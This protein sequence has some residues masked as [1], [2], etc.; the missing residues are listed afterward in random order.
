[1]IVRLRE[2]EKEIIK[3]SDNGILKEEAH[4]GSGIVKDEDGEY[5]YNVGDVFMYLANICHEIHNTGNIESEY[6]FI[7]I[8]K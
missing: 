6:I 5:P 2:S 7:R 8:H 4:E 3:S 1:M